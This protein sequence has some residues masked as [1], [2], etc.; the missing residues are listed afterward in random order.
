MQPARITVRSIH[1]EGD[2]QQTLWPALAWKE[3]TLA[4]EGS[5]LDRIVFR[6][7]PICRP[8]SDKLTEPGTRVK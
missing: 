6:E 3:A 5:W 1:K 7:F 2:N 4:S 8:P